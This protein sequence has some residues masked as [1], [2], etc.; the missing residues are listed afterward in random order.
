MLRRI[1]AL[2]LLSLLFSPVT[3]A[4]RHVI[5]QLGRNVTVPDHIE[6]AVVLQHQTLNLLV[7]LGAMDQ[8]VGVL[9]SWK[10]QLGSNYL[11][12]APTL[13]TL[14]EPGDITSVNME[15]LLALHP[16]VVFVA[17]YAP[18]AM[19]AQIEQAG[20]P[21]V[22]I[23][24]RRVSGDQA[25]KLNPTLANEDEVYTNGLV[26]GIRL[27]AQVMGHTDRAEAMIKDTLAGR[28]LVSQRLKDLKPD[29][30]VRV[31]MANPGL[32]T[33]GS[34]KYTGLMME[35]AGASNVAAKDIKGYQQVSIE[36]VLKWNPQVIF[37]QERYPEVVEEITHSEQWQTIDAVKHHRIY[38]MPE[39]AKAWGYPMPEAVALGELWMA[40]TLY[41][42]RFSD[43]SLQQQ[44]DHYYQRYYHATCCAA[45]S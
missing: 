44:V 11:R 20:I 24:L 45:K 42:T 37:V 12:L 27:I 26:D 43:I 23:S 17:N 32:T 25:N 21:V 15:S 8:V 19:I 39:Y 22:G 13:A 14:P 10:K 41:P 33:Y 34:G 30:R 1:S 3:W 16:Q 40:K 28:A 2:L 4:D 36:D 5:D 35:H 18:S 9:G 31:Y 6:R 7:Q 38:L 29:A